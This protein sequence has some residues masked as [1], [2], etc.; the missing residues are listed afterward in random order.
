MGASLRPITNLLAVVLALAL[1]AILLLASSGGDDRRQRQLDHGLR[2]LR[3]IGTAMQSEVVTADGLELDVSDRFRALELAFGTAATRLENLAAELETA[4]SSTI[5]RAR[6][7]AVDTFNTIDPASRQRLE[8]RALITGLDGVVAEAA[9]LKADVVAFAR[10]Q[11][12]YLQQRDALQE[13]G[14]DLVRRLRQ[15]SLESA[16]D[17]AFAGIQQALDRIRR[18]VA[19]DSTPVDTTLARL[20]EISVPVDTLD[21]EIDTLADAV[22]G[23]LTQRLGTSGYLN[24]VTA[25]SV[26]EL[27]EGLREQVSG[28]YLYTLRTVGEA[29]VLL[30]VYT[31]MM[32]L[33]LVY[34][35]VRLQLNHLVLNR[36]HTLLEE[37]V[38]ERTAE[39]ETAYEELKESQVQLVQAE[40]MSSLGQLV[41]GVVH[42]INTPL[43]YVMNN[44]EMTRETIEE[45]GRDIEPLRQLVG[46]L[47]QPEL[48]KEQVRAL[49]DDLRTSLD[50]EALDESLS[51]IASLTTDSMEGLG[52][53]DALV[54]SLKD[55]SRLDRA[56]YDRFDVREGLEKTLLITKNLLKYGIEVERD[57]H[58]VPEILCAPSRVNQVFINLITN[59]AQAMDGQGVLKIS[60]YADDDGW[61]HVEI[62]DTGCGIPQE[63]LDKV[64]DPFFT[65]KPVGQG[66]GLGLSIVRKIMDEHHGQ[67]LID[68]K[69]GTGTQ[70]TLSFP[71]E[72]VAS[73]VERDDH[74]DA[75]EAA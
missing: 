51:E 34:F 71:V 14:R 40:K 4:Q 60:T 22:S 37:R 10:E 57:F 58:D 9:V 25:S 65:T 44:T 61:V 24:R 49:L 30:N 11:K 18:T 7:L 1:L 26:P 66:T 47:K 43:L 5:R 12:A 41:A 73:E 21:T 31:L 64:L 2:E 28:D 36:S 56:T 19:D 53:I 33:I 27:A 38:K 13:Q 72:G 70:I 6:N 23:L 42:E 63:N 32:L 16:A 17:A 59:A 68:S 52:D 74:S 50:I 62:R 39:L 45:V 55:F 15:R 75:V 3:E 35:G 46:C 69:E 48:P 54:K 8:P 20:R 29:R 67:L